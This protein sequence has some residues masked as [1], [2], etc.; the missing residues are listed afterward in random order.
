[1]KNN[2]WLQHPIILEGEKVK[3]LPLEE[4]H[5]DE[6]ISI[7][8]DEKIWKH[9]PVNYSNAEKHRKMLAEALECRNDGSRYPFVIIDKLTN[10][11]IGCTRYFLIDSYNKSLEI[12]FTWYIPSYWGTN[13]NTECKLLLLTHCFEALRTARVQLKTC[14]ENIRSQ[15]AIEKIGAKFEGILRK[16]RLRENGTYRSSAYFSIVDE[17]WPMSKQKL[18]NCLSQKFVIH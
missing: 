10:R 2:S 17:E 8:A 14:S 13:Y 1:M 15:K 3:L 18:L 11:I 12:G 6:I 7:A 16:D 9:Y 4:I 5:F